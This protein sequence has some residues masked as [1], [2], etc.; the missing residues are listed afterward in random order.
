MSQTWTSESLAETVWALNRLLRLLREAGPPAISPTADTYRSQ[1]ED[2]LRAV[3]PALS[4]QNESGQKI[5][6]PSFPLK[7][8]ELELLEEEIHQTLS[9]RVARA[10]GRNQAR[11]HAAWKS[12][13]SVEASLEHLHKTLRQAG[14]SSQFIIEAVAVLFAL[15]AICLLAVVALRQSLTIST[16]LVVIGLAGNLAFLALIVWLWLR[17]HG[18]LEQHHEGLRWHAIHHEL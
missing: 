8:S 13:L 14:E 17:H 6:V 2:W 18:H 4:E 15:D 9:K 12:A 7:G 11:A 1:V 16:R 10:K 3:K 5:S